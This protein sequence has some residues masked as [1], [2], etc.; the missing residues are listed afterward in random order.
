M[1]CIAAR[2]AGASSIPWAPLGPVHV[3]LKQI[4]VALPEKC[5]ELGTA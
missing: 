4:A 2:L 1:H 5:L 3:D